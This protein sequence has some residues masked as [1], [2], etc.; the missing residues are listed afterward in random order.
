VIPEIGRIVDGVEGVA[1]DALERHWLFLLARAADVEPS[2][3]TVD[4]A[5]AA[6]C[7]DD[8]RAF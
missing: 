6:G 3:L 5:K 8:R 2:G 4:G 1:G 7:P